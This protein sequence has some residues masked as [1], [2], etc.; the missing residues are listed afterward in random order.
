MEDDAV[1]LS[2]KLR[3]MILAFFLS[4]KINLTLNNRAQLLFFFTPFF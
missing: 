3:N 2:E 1:V 4:Q